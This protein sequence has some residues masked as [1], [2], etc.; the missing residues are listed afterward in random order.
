MPRK[1]KNEELGRKTVEEFKKAPKI[2][3]VLVLDNIRS[4]NNTGSVFRTADAFLAEKIILCG[5]TAVPPHP[6]IHKTALGATESVTWEYREDTASTIQELRKEGYTIVSVE[7]AENNIPLN[8]FKVDTNRK[9]ALVF[10]HEIHGVRQDVVDLSDAVIAV[11]QYGTKHS[12]NVAVCAG[13]VV[14]EF[15]TA[16]TNGK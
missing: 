8:Q 13:I 2:P 7:Q 5:I 10:G 15:F 3:L 4:Q 16:F 6:E 14:W 11:P 12:L 1:L 9:Y